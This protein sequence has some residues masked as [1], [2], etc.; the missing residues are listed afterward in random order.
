[1]LYHV[2]LEYQLGVRLRWIHKKPLLVTGF[3]PSAVEWLGSVLQ[4]LNKGRLLSNPLRSTEAAEIGLENSFSALVPSSESDLMQE[5]WD[6]ILSPAAVAEE[7]DLYSSRSKW[8][9][10]LTFWPAPLT[11]CDFRALMISPWLSYHFRMR[12]LIIVPSAHQFVHEMKIRKTENR[13]IIRLEY[14][15]SLVADNPSLSKIPFNELIELR[16]TS[17]QFAAVYAILNN[18]IANCIIEDPSIIRIAY[19][20]LSSSPYQTLEYLIEKTGM[21]QRQEIGEA[22]KAI[23]ISYDGSN[24][25]KIPHSPKDPSAWQTGLHE[26]QIHV[27]NE[28][29]KE[30]GCPVDGFTDWRASGPDSETKSRYAV[31]SSGRSR[32]AAGSQREKPASSGSN[33]F[34]NKSSEVNSGLKPESSKKSSDQMS[35]GNS[36]KSRSSSSGRRGSSSRSS[37]RGRDRNNNDSDY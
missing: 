13:S 4:I 23:R 17:E 10:K 5:F 16:H 15:E 7:A 20:D 1:M 9:S 28:V 29:L 36:N 22:L 35:G 3:L 34:V 19:E 14:L 2:G 26:A 18:F 8:L 33:S 32:K 31:R 21:R 12:P 37:R 6:D 25:Q 30:M 11:V 27:V 24:Y